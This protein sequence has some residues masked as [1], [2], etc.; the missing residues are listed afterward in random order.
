MPGIAYQDQRELFVLRTELTGGTWFGLKAMSALTVK[1]VS[2][3]ISIQIL[4]I[5]RVHSQ[6]DQLAPPPS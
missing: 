5:S 2:L 4:N 1:T 6:G 3:L